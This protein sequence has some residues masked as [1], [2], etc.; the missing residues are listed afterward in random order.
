MTNKTS[1]YKS[2]PVPWRALFQAY[3]FFW[4][5]RFLFWK[6]Y[7]GHHYFGLYKRIV[8]R[9]KHQTIHLLRNT[10][11]NKALWKTWLKYRKF[12]GHLNREDNNSKDSPQIQFIKVTFRNNEHIK[13][14]KSEPRFC[15]NSTCDSII[16]YK[17]TYAPHSIGLCG[18]RLSKNRLSNT[19]KKKNNNCSLK[20]YGENFLCPPYGT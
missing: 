20:K 4:V 16:V 12:K 11:F 18:T 19:K 10:I 9:D 8:V 7:R 13:K 17:C 14:R 15:W 1:L 5:S 2:C 6:L 3:E